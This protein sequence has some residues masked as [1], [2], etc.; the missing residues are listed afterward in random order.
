MEIRPHKSDWRK[1][2][3]VYIKKTTLAQKCTNKANKKT[4]EVPH[5]SP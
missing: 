5:I 2:D 1:L 4:S 3:I